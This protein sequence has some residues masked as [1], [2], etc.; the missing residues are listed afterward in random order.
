LTEEQK[1]QRTTGA[2][3]GES[4]PS[5]VIN[6]LSNWVPLI[7]NILVGFLLTPFL[8]VRLGNQDYGIWVVVGS[9]VGYYGLLRLGVGVG[10]IRYVPYYRGLNDQKAVREIIST[11]VVLFTIAGFVIMVVSFITAEPLTRYFKGGPEFTIMVRILGVTALIECVVHVLDSCVRSYERWV[12]ANFVSVTGA[13]FRAVGLVVFLQL[14]YGLVA[15]SYVVLAT[16]VFSLVL[17]GILFLRYCK[18]INLRFK[19]VNVVRIKLLISYGLIITIGSAGCNLR[20][21]GHGLIIGKLLSLEAVTIYAIAVVI[22][23]NMNMLSITPTRVFWPRFSHLDGENRQEELTSL[24]LTTTRFCAVITS[25]AILMVL[26]LGPSFIQLWVGVGFESV[27]PVIMVLALGYLI[28]ASLGS[29]VALLG[30]TGRQKWLATI[31]CTETILG[32]G[33]SIFLVGEMELIGVALGFLISSVVVNGVVGSLIVCHLLKIRFIQ[34][35][36]QCVFRPWL[37]LGALTFIVYLLNLKRYADSW[38]VLIV[39]GL[40]VGSV[41][42]AVSYFISFHVHEKERVKIASRRGLGYMTSLF[43]IILKK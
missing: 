14:G 2:P 16:S 27:Y 1:K 11:A 8:I 17:V 40:V 24:F 31:G 25:G 5:F 39:L 12:M 33:L 38:A 43:G 35:Y 34:D 4:K 23:R 42:A 36:L 18:S 19:S 21:A 26:T 22:M 13:V 28:E 20:L 29:T 15:M 6:I 32:I 9:I 30:A 3:L 41:Y 10:V 37:L 7:V